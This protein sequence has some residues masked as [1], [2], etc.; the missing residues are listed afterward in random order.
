MKVPK[1]GIFF[2]K[3]IEGRRR[4]RNGT[5]LSSKITTLKIRK[6]RRL[7]ARDWVERERRE[8]EKQARFATY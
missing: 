5:L 7:L 8:G 4:R 1:G 6:G 2:K 3:G